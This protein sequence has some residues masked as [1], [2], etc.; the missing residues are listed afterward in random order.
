MTLS[1]C[2]FCASTRAPHSSLEERAGLACR[3]QHMRVVA[4]RSRQGGLVRGDE[5]CQLGTL[6]LSIAPAY[7][8]LDQCPGAAC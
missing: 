2:I 1:R 8:I 4:C 6:K 5:G 3:V 7:L